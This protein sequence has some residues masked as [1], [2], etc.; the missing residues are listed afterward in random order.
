MCGRSHAFEKPEPLFYVH[1]AYAVLR[2]A[3]RAVEAVGIERRKEAIVIRWS[4]VQT[5][6]RDAVKR[7]DHP[8]QVNEKIE[9]TVAAVI[10]SLFRVPSVASLIQGG[11]AAAAQVEGVFL[12]AFGILTSYPWLVRFTAV[13]ASVHLKNSYWHSEQNL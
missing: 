2:V 13:F 4:L 6:I 1:L 11:A 7:L 3:L 12:W 10:C 9:L 5:T 8:A